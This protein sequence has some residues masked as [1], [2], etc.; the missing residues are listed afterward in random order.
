MLLCFVEGCLL[1]HNLLRS[2]RVL[3]SHLRG[4]I[5]RPLVKFETAQM[6]SVDALL[7]EFAACALI[8]IRGV[9]R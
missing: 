3:L 9:C 1:I 2:F 8:V 5:V 7:L 6:A 4:R